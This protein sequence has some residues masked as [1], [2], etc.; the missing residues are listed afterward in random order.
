MWVDYAEGTQMTKAKRGLRRHFYKFSF[1]WSFIWP[2]GQ[3]EGSTLHNTFRVW[4]ASINK[5]SR[6]RLTLLGLSYQCSLPPTGALSFVK[7]LV[8]GV[9]LPKSFLHLHVHS[10]TSGIPRLH[11]SVINSWHQCGFTHNP[12]MHLTIGYLACTVKSKII[13]ALFGV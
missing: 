10:T 3:N 9:I 11:S 8:A 12:L 4:N 7:D 5:V 13:T 2:C 6:Q 1:R